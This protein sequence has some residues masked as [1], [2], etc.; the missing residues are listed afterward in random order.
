M[1]IDPSIKVYGDKTLRMK[2]PPSEDAE[3]KTIFNHLRTNKPELAMLATHV[4]NE[5]SKTQ[6]QAAKDAL[7]GLTKGFCD[8]VIVGDPVFLCELK[9]RDFTKSKISKEQERFLIESS[10]TGAFACVALG[11]DGFILALED[12]QKCTK[13][14]RNG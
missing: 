4:L 2:R 9:K 12:W 11:F 1:K 5:G 6:A 7:M 10:K 13:K 8:I 14:T 3:Q